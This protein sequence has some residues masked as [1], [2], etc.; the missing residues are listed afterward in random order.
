MRRSFV[1]I[2][3]VSLFVNACN[4][5]SAG[6]ARSDVFCVGL[7]TAYGRWMITASTSPRGRAFNRRWPKDSLTQADFIETIDARDRAKN[8]QTFLEDGYDL[9]VT[10]GI[11]NG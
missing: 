5:P 9:I 6:C 1:C 2:L 3:L 8:I 4:L 11:F 7:V 10:V